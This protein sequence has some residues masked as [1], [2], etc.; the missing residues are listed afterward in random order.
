V[1]VIGGGIIGVAAAL[2]LAERGVA[3][4]VLEKGEIGAEQSSRNWGW[5]R[6]SNRD[7]R[8]FDLIRESLRLWRGLDARV[9]GDTGF[10]TTG[11]LFAAP[12]EA[13]EQS[14]EAW[15]GRAAPAGIEAS[16]I[17]GTELARLLPGDRALPRAALYCASDGRAEPALAAP[18]IAHA[19]RRSGALI[20]THCAARGIE[21]SA[22][23]V[24]GVVTERGT[25]ACNSVVVAGGAWSRRILRDVGV[26]LPQLKVRSSVART[27]VVEGGPEAALWDT[28]FAIRRRRDGG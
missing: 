21:R 17:R 6:Q 16:V 20:F 26:T 28:G 3:V 25:I 9:G 8:E 1:V 4:T 23:S 24:C 18:A 13:A 15:V 2:A 14:Y 5:C 11:I 19:A 10:R 7:P 12:D 27:T 22:G